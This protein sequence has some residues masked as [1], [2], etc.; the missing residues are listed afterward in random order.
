MG[1]EISVVIPLLNEAP[2]VRPLHEQLKKALGT[3]NHEI[4]FVDDG[5]TDNT[6]QVLTDLVNEDLMT[7]VVRLRKNF[8][9]AAAYSAGFQN[10]SG[11]IVVTMDGDLQDDPAE[12]HKF[13]AKMDEGY[14]A[15]TGWKYR[16]KGRFDKAIA[17]RIFNR[18]T[19]F[20]T[21]IK[22]H[23]FNCPYKAYRREVLDD[24]VLYGDLFRFIP[25]LLADKGYRIAEVKIENHTRKFGKSKYS[26]SRYLR[27]SFDMITILFLTKFRH[28][29][30][31][32]FGSIGVSMFAAGFLIDLYL[33]YRKIFSGLLIS[34]EPLLFLG[35][36][37]MFI[38]VQFISIGLITEMIVN[39]FHEKGKVNYI[40]EILVHKQS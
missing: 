1:T 3:L 18:L 5:S 4:I 2:N 25:V 20:L 34:K 19:S 11:D 39:S 30:L 10:A 28:S 38:G 40:R 7:K 12:I 21:G 26:F 15:V 23:D 32:L 36:L 6:F 24:I 27:T 8:G 37:L 35:I 14:D 31:Y 22:L 13:L 9:K 16:G 33:T 17:S 29:P